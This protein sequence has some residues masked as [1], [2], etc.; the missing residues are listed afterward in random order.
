MK[1]LLYEREHMGTG[2]LE[3][4]LGSFVRGEGLVA[5]QKVGEFGE[6]SDATV[7]T[8]MEVRKDYNVTV[9]IERTS[10]EGPGHQAAEERSTEEE[11]FTISL[12]GGFVPQ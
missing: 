12:N 6:S 2:H 5:H 7:K 4:F 3:Y 10:W 1:V 11:Q 8:N 9:E